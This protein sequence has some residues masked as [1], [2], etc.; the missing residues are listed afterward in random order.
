[1][2]LDRQSQCN[3]S[4]AVKLFKF[5]HGVAAVRLKVPAAGC[6]YKNHAYVIMSSVLNQKVKARSAAKRLQ[7][8]EMATKRNRRVEDRKL[9]TAY[10]APAFVAPRPLSAKMRG[11]S[12]SLVS[13]LTR[14]LYKRPKAVLELLEQDISIQAERLGQIENAMLLP[15]MQPQPVAIPV[16]ADLP[17]EPPV[18]TG[19]EEYG[20]STV[21]EGPSP[22][23]YIKAY[24]DTA[25]SVQEA[26]DVQQYDEARIQVVGSDTDTQPAEPVPVS[27][28]GRAVRPRL[29]AASRIQR[30]IY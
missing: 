14:S 16:P 20:E 8:Q 18:A 23:R 19:D 26:P 17:Y 24:L 13:G 15:L 3:P 21:D 2:R 4:I 7:G 10:R 28:N 1:M 12:R 25:E 30:R 6:L 11:L 5:L 27:V 22:E 9:Q 29:T